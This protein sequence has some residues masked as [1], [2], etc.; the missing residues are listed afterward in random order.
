MNKI[1]K[2][3]LFLI[4]FLTIIVSL[5]FINSNSYKR[6]KSSCKLFREFQSYIINNNWIDAQ[7]L[8]FSNE[9]NNEQN[10]SDNIR[11]YI[12]NR[13]TI[14]NGKIISLGRDITNEITKAKPR[15]WVTYDYYRSH[16]GYVDKVILTNGY[17]LLL[18]SQI[19]YIKIQ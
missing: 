18:N 9:N 3:K 5:C 13:V 16:T 6:A 17:I 15:F 12:T 14:K 2:Y 10:Y 19:L 7:R 8:V 1:R 4:V 11:F